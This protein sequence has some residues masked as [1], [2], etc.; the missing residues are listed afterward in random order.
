[1]QLLKDLTANMENIM[2]C[3]T[4]RIYEM[5]A[6]VERPGKR[7]AAIS[8]RQHEELKLMGNTQR[9]NYMRNQPCVCGSGKKFKRCCWSKY[10]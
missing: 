5:T 2:D 1:M 9:K 4:G 3:N 8:E 6:N 10:A 7:L